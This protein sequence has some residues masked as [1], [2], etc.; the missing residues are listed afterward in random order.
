MHYIL[1][2]DKEVIPAPL[3]EWASFF[4]EGNRVVAKSEA[5]AIRPDG[6]KYTVEVSTVFLGLDH[7]YDGEG[8]P[9]VFETM[10]FGGELDQDMERC[11]TWVQA[12]K[13]HTRMCIRVRRAY[14]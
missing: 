9:I 11:S 4:E 2:K 6:S 7:R 10:V 13:M 14:K 8:P 3:R 5:E 1:N 12:K